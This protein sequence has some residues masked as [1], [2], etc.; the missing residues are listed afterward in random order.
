[1]SFQIFLFAAQESGQPELGVVKFSGEGFFRQLR[2]P[3]PGRMEKLEFN[4]DREYF[5]LE[6][7]LFSGRPFRM[8]NLGAHDLLA[9]AYLPRNLL[10]GNIAHASSSAKC[11]VHCPDGRTSQSC[12][13]CRIEKITVK[14]CC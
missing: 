8:L 13:T 14:I 10:L 5:D 11:E 7:S 9:L 1:M 12:I 2:Y 6:L 4:V 3:E